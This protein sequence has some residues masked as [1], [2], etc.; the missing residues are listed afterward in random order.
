MTWT[1]Q[2]W[3]HDGK[4]YDGKDMRELLEAIFYGNAGV[5]HGLAVSQQGSPG[6]TV[7]VAAGKAIIAA[8][9][10][11]LYG[12]YHA[13]NDAA[14]NSPT[15]DPTTTNGRKDRLI[16]RVTS[17]VPALEV[18][19]GTASGSPAEPAITGD[20]YLELALITL[21][22]STTNITNAMITDRRVYAAA[23]GGTVL[24]TSGD[25]ISGRRAGDGRWDSDTSRHSRWN[26]SAWVGPTYT[27]FTPQLAQNGN[28]TS[29]TAVGRYRLD[30][31][32]CHLHIRNVC[33]NAGTAGNQITINN[34]PAAIA[35]LK[36]GQPNGAG[37]T[38]A[39]G[40]G[41]VLDNGTAYYPAH[42]YFADSTTLCFYDV[43]GFLGINIG[44]NPSF[45]LASGD[46]VGVDMTYE[47]A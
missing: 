35:P 25:T 21:P 34:I 3:G 33:S 17:G 42:A 7:Q 28:R 19:K 12:Y 30:G 27:T 31:K 26:G 11:G 38:S 2:A 6:S 15:I 10:S 16:V 36:T 8:S 9:G 29:S 5:I 4:T 24:A 47:I 23:V 22:G 20:N 45:A 44:V 18:V 39:V 1:T 46:A 41:Y 14:A 40:L 32:T 37:D 43:S 13:W